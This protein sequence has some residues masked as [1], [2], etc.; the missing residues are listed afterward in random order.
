[1]KK[2]KIILSIVIII[3]L[4]CILGGGYVIKY[5]LVDTGKINLEKINI[6][7]NIS[8]KN[9]KIIDDWKYKVDTSNTNSIKS[10]I[11]PGLL[12]ST[13]SYSPSINTNIATDAVS[14]SFSDNTLGL[15]T[16][17][18]KNINNFR[19]NIK[20]GY[21]PIST[22]ITYNGLYYDYYFDTGKIAKSTELFSPS[23]STAISKDPISGQLEYYMTVG[24]NSNIKQSDFQ[25]KKLNLVMVLDISGSMSSRFNSYYYDG[26]NEE[27]GE[28]NKY[29]KDK[30]KTKMQIANESVNLLID[31]LN[32]ED[33]LGIVLFDDESYLAKPL[34]LVGETDLDK[35]KEHVLE[36]Q[37]QGGTNF[38]AGFTSGTKLFTEEMLEDSEYENRIIV[39][40]DAMPNMG[41]TSKA[42]LAKY[43]EEN[44]ENGI[45]TSFIGVG[46]D[47]NTQV[48]ECLSDVKGANYY[49]VHSS[50]EFKKIMSEDFDYMVT[51]LV[52]DLE[53]NFDSDV[54]SIEKVY[55]TDTVDAYKGNIM[56]VNTLFP[57]SSNSSGEAKGGIILLKLKCNLTC[58]TQIEE[59]IENAKI[60]LSVSY[61]DRNGEEHSNSQN[62]QF[63]EMEQEHYDNTG[64][65]KGIVLARYANLMKNWILYERSDNNREFLIMAEMG[66]TDC[67]CEVNEVYKILGE[68]E[69]RSVELSVSDEYKALFKEFY[70]YMEK[71]IEVLEDKEMKQE[72]EIL[73]LLI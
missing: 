28:E 15:S 5:F 33:R 56:K 11:T 52:F 42:G 43:V 22:D 12:N 62:V 53:L 6:L 32:E 37:P 16:G 49:S 34:N 18:A 7:A 47:F 59:E 54:F 10:S 4:L 1:M 61:K 66:I 3:I 20:N 31:E 57:S 45:Y 67:V 9:Q 71:E 51:P 70:R 8:T 58:G 21:F 44:A 14:E 24:L 40:T 26:L 36:I 55:G 25:R 46:V 29:A 73:D 2:K 13:G 17:G 63:K 48:I 41:Q 19:E 69:R 39:I 68:N 30:N 38:Q 72:L 27:N 23:Y 64:I 60:N 50:E 65:R 35:I